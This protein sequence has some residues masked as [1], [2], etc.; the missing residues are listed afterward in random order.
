LLLGYSCSY[1]T[2]WAQRL[3]TGLGSGR[4]GYG[5]VLVVAVG[6]VFIPMA[7]LLGP[8]FSLGL[9]LVILG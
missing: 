4:D 7:Q 6:V 5:L 2:M 8:A 1:V 3:V 9:G